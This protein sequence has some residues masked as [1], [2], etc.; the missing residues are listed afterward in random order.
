MDKYSTLGNIYNG[1]NLLQISEPTCSLANEHQTCKANPNYK[2]SCEITFEY[3]PITNPDWS[4]ARM[5]C[6]EKS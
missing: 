3:T 1:K 4:A 2:P 6:S 5:K